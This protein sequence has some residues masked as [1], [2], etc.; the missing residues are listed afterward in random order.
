MKTLVGILAVAALS[1]LGGTALGGILGRFGLL[2][3]LPVGRHGGKKLAIARHA[4]RVGKA[5][6]KAFDRERSPKAREELKRWLQENDPKNE[7][8]LG[9][10]VFG[11]A[12]EVTDLPVRSTQTGTKR[13]RSS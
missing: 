9:D 10:G 2:G 4:L 3:F 8:G 1:H 5:L 6:R 7:T 11:V 12:D 13:R